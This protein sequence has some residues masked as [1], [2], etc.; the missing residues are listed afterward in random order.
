MS[1]F[2]RLKAEGQDLGVVRQTGEPVARLVVVREIFGVN[3]HPRSVDAGHAKNGFLARAPDLF[4]R[5]ES[6][7]ES[8]HRRAYRQ[9][10]MRLLAQLDPENSLF[11]FA[12]EL[13]SSAPGK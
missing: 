8:D 11:N 2:V 4:D 7:V 12:I 10:A 13:A 5:I 3:R 6:G 9:K 1:E